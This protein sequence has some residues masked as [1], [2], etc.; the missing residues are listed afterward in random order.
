[1]PMCAATR[2]A[3]AMSGEPSR[4]MQKE[5]KRSALPASRYSLTATAA[6]REESRPPESRRP[7]GTSD[8]KW[9]RTLA[10]NFC[11]NSAKS[12]TLDGK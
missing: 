12:S 8:N 4:P 6:T 10:V 11:R 2:S 1:V 9:R 7:K 3:A 5:R